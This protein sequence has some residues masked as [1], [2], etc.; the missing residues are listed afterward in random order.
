[1]TS[2]GVRARPYHA[3]LNDNKRVKTLED[4]LAGHF[5]LVCATIAFGMGI[6]KSD[7]RYVFHYSA[8]KSIEGYY[9]EAGEC[10]LDTVNWRLHFKAFN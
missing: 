5:E 1:M 7:V 3:G 10:S 6:D 9:Q 8:P 2:R 4:W